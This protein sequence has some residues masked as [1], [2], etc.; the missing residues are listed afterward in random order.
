MMADWIY[1]YYPWP[2]P[3]TPLNPWPSYVPPMT[4]P[5]PVAPFNPQ[6]T[7]WTREQLEEAE[8][9]LARIKDMEEKLG[10]CPCEDPS[11]M[12]FLKEIRKRLDALEQKETENAEED[13]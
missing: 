8:D 11:K 7:P 3:T 4:P 6:P 10:G 13:R 5:F 9:I 1:K 2:T 12:D